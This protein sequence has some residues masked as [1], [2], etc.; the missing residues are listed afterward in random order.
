MHDFF[1]LLNSPPEG[2]QFTSPG[3]GMG[4]EAEEARSVMLMT[5]FHLDKVNQEELGNKRPTIQ[6][7]LKVSS[8]TFAELGE[9]MGL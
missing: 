8:G 3:G 6:P 4:Q 2:S 5:S 1:L 7:V 9:L